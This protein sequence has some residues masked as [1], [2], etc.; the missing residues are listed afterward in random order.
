MGEPESL[1]AKPQGYSPSPDPL[2]SRPTQQCRVSAAHRH[3]LPTSAVQPPR[4]LYTDPTNT[5]DSG[6]AFDTTFTQ[7]APLPRVDTAPVYSA[8]HPHPITAKAHSRSP[9]SIGLQLQTD[10]SRLS[11]RPKD[12][13]VAPSIINTPAE[14]LRGSA[15]APMDI[16]KT[17]LRS[18]VSA[19]S[20][21]SSLSPSSAISSPALGALTDITPLPSPLVMNDSPG[22][23]RRA[24]VHQRP[25]SGGSSGTGTVKED[26]MTMLSN[27]TLSPSRT[28]SKKHKGYSDL[29][30]AAVEANG[31]N[32]DKNKA[33]HGRNRSLSE[34]V[35]EHAYNSRPRNVTVS[36]G[37]NAPI[38]EE[39]ESTPHLHREEY[40]AEQRGLAP[41]SGAAPRRTLPTP[42][43][44]NRSSTESEEEE[45]KDDADMEG[46]E[47]LAI[48]HDPEKKKKKIYRPIRQL[49]QGTFSKVLLATRQKLASKE[50]PD[51]SELDPN[52]LVAIKIVEHGPAGG[53]DEERVELSLKR[54]VEMLKSVHHPSLIRLKAFDCDEN[55]ALLVLTYTPGGDL[56]DLASSGREI[57]TAGLVQRMFAELVGA[58]R[59]L[60]KELIVH[61]DIKLEN[62][63]LN[64]PVSLLPS[65]QPP[66]SHRYP[67]ITLTDLGLSRRIEPASPLLTT[68]CGS[69]DYAAPE[70][71]LGQEYDGR[72]T[73]AWAVGVLLYA[74]ME[75]RLPF[76]P[77]P[78]KARGRSRAVHRI[79][80][81]DWMWCRFGDE[82]GDWDE[83]KPETSGWEGARTVVEGLL[84]KVSRGR[85]PL[86]D[87]EQMEW[88]RE[89]ITV[90]GGLKI[91]GEDE[92]NADVPMTG[93]ATR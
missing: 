66:Q 31:A 65:I 29:M 19:A 10:F 61:R 5:T 87:V 68:R 36:S 1:L 51:E 20:L 67:L 2:P 57:L 3:E 82:N 91:P 75:G 86:E 44:S 55:Q 73:D 39:A 46:I 72:Q 32:M 35:P 42:P 28:P 27:G 84:K 45:M 53:A 69:E 17:G 80:R 8:I 62:V 92:G 41:A 74:L 50:I 4:R 93:G 24:M 76:D 71:L 88:V 83:S 49:G 6:V 12:S 81:C 30:T 14:E 78:G 23:W 59:Y 48:R 56:F 60:H 70:I 37:T 11:S 21:A 33:S 90:E 38:T 63:L 64:Y 34:Y 52:K 9:S 25:G 79:A 26:S 54:E 77:P 47:Y 85:L 43:P 7:N 58:V 22:P 18:N 89:G 40:L 13:A 16:Q 15:T